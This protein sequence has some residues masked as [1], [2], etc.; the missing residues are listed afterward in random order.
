MYREEHCDDKVTT[1]CQE[2]MQRADA[3]LLPSNHVCVRAL[4][5]HCSVLIG[6]CQLDAALPHMRPAICLWPEL[7]V[8]S[9]R[10]AHHTCK[11]SSASQ[12][13]DDSCFCLLA[14]LRTSF[15]CT[16]RASRVCSQD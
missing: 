2:H 1:A 6:S 15:D 8:A 12:P 11:S 9:Q 16:V 7:Q 13:D 5:A 3:L 4:T 14:K 10:F